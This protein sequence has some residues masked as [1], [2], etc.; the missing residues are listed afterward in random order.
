MRDAIG[1][2]AAPGTSIIDLREKKFHFK[3]ACM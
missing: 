1:M 2:P 3:Y